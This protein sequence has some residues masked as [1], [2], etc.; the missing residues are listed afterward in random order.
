MSTDLEPA[1]DSV[2]AR[3][4]GRD[5]CDDVSAELLEKEKS[6][7]IAEAKESGKP[8]N[9]VEKMVAGRIKKFLAE[10]TLVGQPF[11]K[12]PDITI[13]KLLE[14][15]GA[16]VTF[17]ERFEVGEGIEKKRENFAD[18]VMAQVQGS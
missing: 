13:A 6:I 4:I 15:V 10:I 17:F 12:D 8:D 2:F 18:E 1:S 9:I 5:G 11:V 3:V 16:T 14:T 7:L